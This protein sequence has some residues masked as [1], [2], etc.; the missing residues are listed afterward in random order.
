[1]NCG[2]QISVFLRATARNAKR[3]LGIVITSVRLSD[4]TRYRFK[5]RWDRDSWFLPY[6]SV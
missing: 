4:T 3:V 6:D 1:M 2:S 5:P